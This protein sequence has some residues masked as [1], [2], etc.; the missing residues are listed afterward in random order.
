M[1]E[2]EMTNKKKEGRGKREREN[3]MKRG[4]DRSLEQE[5]GGRASVARR[6]GCVCV[7]KNERKREREGENE[8][9]RER[10]S[11]DRHD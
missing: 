10:E 2:G 11:F 1:R 7:G 5:R 9:Q 8:K 4:G 3:R 6:V